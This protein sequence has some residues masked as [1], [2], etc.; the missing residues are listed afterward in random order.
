[1]TIN[2]DK[3]LTPQGAIHSVSKWDDEAPVGTKAV[4][5]PPD[6]SNSEY[7]AYKA[8]VSD[9]NTPTEVTI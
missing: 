6:D 3:R 1:M 9:G 7:Q 4:I 5:I 8:W 2:Y